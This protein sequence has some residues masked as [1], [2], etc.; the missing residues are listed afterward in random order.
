MTYLEGDKLP[1]AH[2]IIKYL[3]LLLDQRPHLNA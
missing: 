1:H 2:L 3:I